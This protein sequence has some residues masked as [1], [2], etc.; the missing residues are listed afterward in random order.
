VR[1]PTTFGHRNELRM[2]RFEP[3]PN[4]SIDSGPSGPTND[5]SPS[6]TFSSIGSATG[7]ECRL[8][9][10]ADFQ[11]CTS[12][13]S[14][15]GLGDGVHTFRVRAKDATYTDP[16][17]A[18]RSFQVDTTP[19]DTAIDALR[20]SRRKHKATLRFSGSDIPPS[21]PPDEFKCSLDGKPFG[22]CD[23]PKRYKKLK[24]RRHRVRVRALDAAGNLDPVPARKRFRI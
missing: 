5:A 14:Y 1:I 18:T 21:G 23:S 6:F 12:P 8:D 2:A 20:V 16:S 13:K 9:A 15:P 7:F 22:A 17:P 24:E 11:S 19:P 3:G 10:E 4:T